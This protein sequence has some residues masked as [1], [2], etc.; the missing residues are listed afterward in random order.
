MMYGAMSGRLDIENL[1]RTPP[2]FVWV[3]GDHVSDT[4][5]QHVLRVYNNQLLTT[6]VCR[7]HARARA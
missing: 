2:R 6:I 7:S 3:S 5:D 4:P 1:T